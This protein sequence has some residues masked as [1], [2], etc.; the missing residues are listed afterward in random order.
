MSFSPRQFNIGLYKEH[1]EE[2]SFLTEQRRT[3][4]ENPEI[5]WPRIG[6]FEERFEAHIDALVVGADLALEVCQKQAAEGDAGEL[7]AAV[8]VFCRQR[9]K[10]L[11][12]KVLATLDVGDPDKVRAVVEALAHELPAEWSDLPRELL[13]GKD[14]KFIGLAAHIAG[15]RRAGKGEDLLAA[16]TKAAPPDLPVV[17]WALG[18]VRPPAAR[19]VPLSRWLSHEDEPVRAAAALALL[20]LGEPQAIPALAEAARSQAW[21]R[22]PLALAGGQATVGIL[23]ETIQPGKTTPDSFLALG[24]LSSSTAVPPLLEALSRPE[25]AEGAALALDLITGAGLTE[26]AFVPEPV[27]EDELFEEEKQALKEGNPPG[28]KPPGT[29]VVRRSQNPQH[30]KAWWFAHQER[31]NSRVRYRQGKPHTP[32]LLAASLEA[33]LTPHRLR[34]FA[35]EELVIRYGADFPFEANLPVEGQRR[36]LAALAQWT[37]TNAARF[38]EGGWYFAGQ[39]SNALLGPVAR[40]PEPTPAPPS[41]RV[42]SLVRQE[43]LRPP[44]PSEQGQRLQEPAPLRLEIASGARAGEVVPLKPGKTLYV[45]RHETAHLVIPGDDRLSDSHFAVVCDDRGC[46]V[47]DLGSRHGTFVNGKKVYEGPIRP[48]DRI[49]AGQTAFVLRGQG[50]PTAG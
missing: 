42:E 47:R 17:L 28:G 9:R 44:E 26:E 31:F 13:T 32:A 27:D 15:Y 3:L 12:Q 14:P 35:S 39:P 33:D 4:F 38:P 41:V 23:L 34:Q 49:D 19:P 8:R 6:E 36:L 25:Q 21:A 48:G 20:R 24:L 46:R 50:G 2:A 43:S 10:D 22:L 16:L 11:L 30:W 45:G 37:R 5:P 7:H 29:T 40:P 1:L 18:R